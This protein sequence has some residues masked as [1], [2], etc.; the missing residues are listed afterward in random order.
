VRNP[1]DEQERAL[2]PEE[3][4]VLVKLCENDLYLFAIRYF[5]HYLKRPSSRLHRFFVWDFGTGDKQIS[6]WCK[7]AIAAPEHQLSQ[8]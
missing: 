1:L 3:I 4:R 5:P 8:P 7:M 2:T 6:K